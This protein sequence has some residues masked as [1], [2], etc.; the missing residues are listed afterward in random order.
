MKEVCK[1]RVEPQKRM[2]TH[3]VTGRERK[4]IVHLLIFQALS[5]I[6]NALANV[7]L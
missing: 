5:R 4:L 1:K 7:N 3:Y 2:V 6:L